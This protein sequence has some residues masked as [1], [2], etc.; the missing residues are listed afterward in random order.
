MDAGPLMGGLG[1]WVPV[2]IRGLIRGPNL[3]DPKRDHDLTI[4]L[5]SQR[6]RGL[7]IRAQGL[8]VRI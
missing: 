3:G 2:I 7:G 4:P 8:G 6:C 5:F 1:F